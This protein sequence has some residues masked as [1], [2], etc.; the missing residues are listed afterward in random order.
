MRRRPY[1]KGEIARAQL[2]KQPGAVTQDSN[3]RVYRRHACTNCDEYYHEIGTDEGSG[4]FGPDTHIDEVLER[5]I[6][7][8]C[9]AQVDMIA[10]G[11]FPELNDVLP[12]GALVR[13]QGFLDPSRRSARA[14]VPWPE[15]PVD[16]DWAGVA[17]RSAPD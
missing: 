9:S 13:M 17:R 16:A 5:T 12:W 8:P 6:C 10:S 1:G 14:E 2:G 7:P 15:N 11:Q 3:G 4:T